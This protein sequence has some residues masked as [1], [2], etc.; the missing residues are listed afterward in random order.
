[1]LNVRLEDIFGAKAGAEP[2]LE[3]PLEARAVLKGDGDS[4]HKAAASADGTVTLVAPHG[5][6]RKAFAELLGV[7]VANGLG[8]LWAKDERET[9]LRC[10]VGNFKAVHGVLHATTFVVDTDV[11]RAD[12]DGVIDLGSEAL[13]LE[14]KGKSKK[15]R[16]LHLSTPVA[17][18]GHLRSPKFGL[19]P[20]AAP[21]QVAGAVALGALLSPVAA[22]L[23]FVD[24]G[25][26][27]DADC[28]GLVST[29]QAKGAPVKP[30]QATTAPSKRH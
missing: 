4:I 26:A 23:P 28:V 27:H 16:I 5:E 17:I 22:I 12:G 10:A 1:V 25:L 14:L 20:G 2:A 19:K 15:F 8:L 11:V 29:A 21:L 13:N 3:G 9:G 6:I 18:S 24:P 7:N 30:S